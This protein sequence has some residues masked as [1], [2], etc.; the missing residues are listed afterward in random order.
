[1]PPLDHTAADRQ[2][3]LLMALAEMN[4]ASTAALASFVGMVYRFMP[5]RL[6]HVQRVA[7]LAVGT[8]G[9]LGL[10]G[11][12]LADLERAALVHD[13]GK[14]VLPDPAASKLVEWS[15]EGGLAARQALT[16]ADVLSSVAFLRPAALVVRGMCEWI[17]GSG[18]P[19]GLS[20]DTIPLSAR[21]LGATDALDVMT[22]VCRE[23][24]WPRDVAVVELVRQA[25]ARF[26][27]N[28]VA[29]AL[30]VDDAPPVESSPW[31]NEPRGVA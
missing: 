15:P 6:A 12:E 21:I 19:F 9:Q 29:A 28:V 26:D 3:R 18:Q 25:G 4:I 30:Q 24:A 7:A 22:D 1:V 23:L 8:G 11:R 16:A 17:D 2:H 5:D 27:A 14:V 13:L 10:R 20:G 31:L